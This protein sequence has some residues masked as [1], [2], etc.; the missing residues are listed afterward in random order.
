MYLIIMFSI[1]GLILK[2][3]FENIK[4]LYKQISLP[5]TLI[6]FLTKLV[7]KLNITSQKPHSPNLIIDLGKPMIAIFGHLLM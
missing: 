6:Y 5:T 4:C 3:F 7:T 2:S 1:F